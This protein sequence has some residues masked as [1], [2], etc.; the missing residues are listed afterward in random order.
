MKNIRI[1]HRA[2]EEVIA[3]G[4]QGW[5]FFSFEGNYYISRNN[6]KTRGFKVNYMPGLCVYKFL[7]VWLNYEFDGAIASSNIAWMY[8]LPNPIFP[9]IWFRVALPANH[10]ELEY[11]Y[12]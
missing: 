11:H 6:V 9:F 1:I 2:T 5:S 10:P 12:Y 3:E 4:V 8:W 7:Y